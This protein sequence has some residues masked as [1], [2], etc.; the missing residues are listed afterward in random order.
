MAIVREFCC[1]VHGPFESTKK[2]PHCPYGCSGS[3][4]Y[5]SPRTPPSVRTD[6]VMVGMDR[7]QT[8]IA[9]EQGLGN[10]RSQYEGE[11]VAGNR[12]RAPPQVANMQQ[13]MGEIVAGRA[14]AGAF[15]AS[16]ADIGL[17]AGS[18]D[19]RKA[20]TQTIGSWGTQKPPANF[21]LPVQMPEQVQA[22]RKQ[23]AEI[24][25]SGKA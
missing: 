2:A 4:V 12:M 5:W 3:V 1:D 10:M 8:R 19:Q 22:E 24:A 20:V 14:P 15:F 6:G 13:R 16:P 23:V 18:Q 25:K 17:Q 21:R 9:D 7:L 11:S